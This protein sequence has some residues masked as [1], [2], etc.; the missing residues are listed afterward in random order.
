MQLIQASDIH[1]ILPECVATVG[2]FDGIH[3]GHQFLI[4]ELKSLAAARG[5][6]SVVITFAVQPRKVLNPQR[7][8]DLIVTLEEKTALLSRTGID[9]CVIIDF[10]LEM[11]QLTAREFIHEVLFDH[12]KVRTLLVGY[13]HRFGHNREDGFAEYKRYG[14]E[15]GMEVIQSVRYCTDTDP[16]ISSTEIR[17]ALLDGDI[18]SANR[19]LGYPYA[20]DGTVT[21]GFKVGRTIGFPT[22]NIQPNHPEKII[23]R[24]GV[25]HVEVEHDGN[26]YAGMLNIGTRPTLDNGTHTSIEVHILNFN[27]DIYHQKIGVK[28]L[29]KIRDEKKFGGIDELKAQLEADKTYVLKMNK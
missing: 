17:S 3:T 22:A 13:D 28:F 16:E 23:P 12:Y 2:I 15:K 8:T 21:E 10:T 4:E 19:M 9:Y 18:E 14:Q 11:A 20:I 5:L 6:K 1:S 7:K 26:L 29:H 25:Y 27:K 24:K